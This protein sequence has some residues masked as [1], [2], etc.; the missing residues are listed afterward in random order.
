MSDK[1]DPQ[2]G[3]HQNGR[4][5][6]DE[7]REPEH[8]RKL[9]IGGL[10]YR[11]TDDT[12]KAYFEKWGKVV[13]V[14]VMKDPKTKRSRGFGFITY[15]KSYM[16]D[17]AQAN[18]PHKID[19]R[20]VEPKR[21]VPRQDI[22]RPEAGSSV[23]KL[24]VGGLRDDFDEEHL[25][26]YFSKYG[27]V[28]SACIVTDKDNGKKRGFGF[29]EFDDYDPVDKIILQKSHTIQNKLLDVKKA[30]PKQDMDRYKNDM[31]RGGGGG[32]GGGGAWGNQRG[33]GSGWNNQRGGG[34]GGGW[35]NQ[36]GGSGAN[37]WNNGGFNSG[38]GFNNGGFNNGGNQWNNG[39]GNPWDNGC[40][41]QGQGGWGNNG[42]NWGGNSGGGGG[43]GGNEFGNNYQQGYNAGPVRAGG[44]FNQRAAP[45]GN[46][47]A[48][49]GGY[50]GSGRYGTNRTY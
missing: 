14:V 33:S 50:S 16:I 13:D 48:G 29:V 6:D 15:S 36:R 41:S 24:F 49:G 38:G 47:G 42:G 43:W 21:A 11:T 18:R 46:Q 3:D 35:G 12:L 23:K 45:Y 27:N 4:N 39:G 19:G 9:F 26:E 1:Q 17:D 30:L 5:D 34:G 20:V 32:G 2:N 8:L 10:D 7:I 37:D 31:G 44:N 28:I 40:G 22:N 25:R